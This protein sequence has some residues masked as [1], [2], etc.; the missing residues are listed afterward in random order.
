VTLLCYPTLALSRLALAALLA[1]A[2][3][4][5]TTLAQVTDAGSDGGDGADAATDA[6]GDAGA[7]A[8]TDG[9]DDAGPDAGPDAGADAGADAGVDAG[10]PPVVLT[11]RLIGGPGSWP[12]PIAGVTF[13]SGGQRGR[14]DADGAFTYEQGTA[15]Q[16]SVYDVAFAPVAGAALVSPYQ[17]AGATC[18][19]S[20]A[21]DA[22]LVLLRGLDSDDDPSNGISVFAG[23]Q[24]VRTPLAQLTLADIDAR[25]AHLYPARALP[26]P[27]VE[28]DAFIRQIDG[29]LWKEVGTGEVFSTQDSLARGQGV[30]TDGARWYFSGTL[31]LQ[32][33]A[34]DYSVIK[35]ATLP[36]AMA[37][38]YKSDHIGDIDTAN[39]ILYA[40]IEDGKNGYK[41]PKLALFDASNLS[42]GKTYDIS[43]SRQTAGVPWV[44]VNGPANELYLAEWNPT[45]LLDVYDLASVS[46]RRSLPLLP[47]PGVTVGRVQGAKLFEGALYLSTDLLNKTIFKMNLEIGTV[48]PLF[49]MSAAKEEEGLAFLA[50]PDGSLMHTLNLAQ[51]GTAE[52]FHHH[53][54]T[55]DPLRK[56][57]CH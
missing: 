48:L 26:Q 55:R 51:S 47:P 50:R 28:L 57:V 40:P 52:E 36:P 46:Y 8:G 3:C 9:G 16:F 34:L 35:T 23:T 43:S 29:E 44:A 32:I 19:R 33:A 18:T 37:L 21:L 30:A 1:L 20:T 56:S 12:G 10:P 24:A 54:R 5:G 49:D 45:T 41:N 31:S 14:T 42:Q 6:G 25:L 2:S 17:L 15:V 38:L 7:D 22:A 13:S 53:A 27:A 4:G 39:G 11:G